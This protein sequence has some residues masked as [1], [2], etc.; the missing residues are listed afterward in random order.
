[1]SVDELA[2][3]TP[4]ELDFEGTCKDGHVEDAAHDQ[5]KAV[6]DAV[7]HGHTALEGIV[8]SSAACTLP[9]ILRRV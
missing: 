9:V 3:S 4:V 2:L 8:H 1:M 6:W 5:L 7:A